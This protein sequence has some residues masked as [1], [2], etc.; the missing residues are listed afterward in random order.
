[1]RRDPDTFDWFQKY[2]GIRHILD[3]ILQNN[4]SH[5]DGVKCLSS[6]YQELDNDGTIFP[7]KDQC[8]V[9]IAGCGNSSLGQDMLRDGWNGAISNIDYSSVVISQMKN[10]CDEDFY[11]KIRATLKREAREKRNEDKENSKLGAKMGIKSKINEVTKMTFTCADITKELEFSNESFDIIINK[12]LLDSILCGNGSDA[13]CRSMMQ[14]CSRLLDKQ[15]GVM[16]IVSHGT[17]GDRLDF[18][19]TT[20]WTGGIWHFPVLKPKVLTER[21]DAS[22]HSNG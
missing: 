19:Q 9:L 14:E 4:V 13:N 18:L 7:T 20:E 17:P 22:S 3:F 1:M 11:R 15:H 5:G 12:G 16:V 21:S 8:R 10:R 6:P 2:N